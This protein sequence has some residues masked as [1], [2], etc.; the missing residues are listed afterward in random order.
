MYLA[1]VCGPAQGGVPIVRNRYRIWHHV[2]VEAGT[3]AQNTLDGLLSLPITVSEPLVGYHEA[4][5]ASFLVQW[6]QNIRTG[7]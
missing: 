2:D 5:R 3:E 1:R 7:V 6:Q 4:A